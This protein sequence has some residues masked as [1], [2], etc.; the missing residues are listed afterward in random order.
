MPVEAEAD[1]LSGTDLRPHEVKP[2]QQPA[3]VDLLQNAESGATVG[4]PGQRSTLESAFTYKIKA[5]APREFFTQRIMLGVDDEGLAGAIA[6]QLRLNDEIL[7]DGMRRAVSVIQVTQSVFLLREES[8]ERIEAE[9]AM[10]QTEIEAQRMLF[11]MV[12]V[13]PRD[14]QARLLEQLRAEYR[15][16]GQSIADNEDQLD[17]ALALILVQHPKLLREAR[18][19]CEA[20]YTEVVKTEPLPPFVQSDTFLAP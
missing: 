19:T 5:D 6:R 9:M 8:R 14:L 10:R 17:V 13:G 20:R 12:T 4:T 15:Q 7:M 1:A 16:R 18:K 2:F 11:D 3:W